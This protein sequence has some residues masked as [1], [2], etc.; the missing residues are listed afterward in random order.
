M[1]LPD[2]YVSVLLAMV[3]RLCNVFEW[4]TTCRV[5]IDD[6]RFVFLSWQIN[7]TGCFLLFIPV[8][9]SQNKVFKAALCTCSVCVSVLY[10]AVL[11]WTAAVLLI[12]CYHKLQIICEYCMIVELENGLHLLCLAK[13]KKNSVLLYHIMPC[14]EDIEYCALLF[15]NVTL[16]QQ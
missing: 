3:P 11:G 12:Q 14:N 13:D 7:F 6:P 1:L 2:A 5:I 10:C 9:A 16:A 8:F 15:K 4:K